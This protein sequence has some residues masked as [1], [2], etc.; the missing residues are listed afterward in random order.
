MEAINEYQLEGS[1]EI[2]LEHFFILTTTKKTE[3]LL[4]IHK[5]ILLLIVQYFKEVSKNLS[6]E[7][8]DRGRL[9]HKCVTLFKEDPKTQ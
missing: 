5:P 3:N 6:S 7:N 2:K 4:L 9:G 8:R 1:I